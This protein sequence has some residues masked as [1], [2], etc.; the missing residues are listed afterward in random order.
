MET[1]LM[2]ACRHTD[3]RIIFLRCIATA[4][5]QH[6]SIAL[7]ASDKAESNTVI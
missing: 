5:P 4:L 1:L 3:Y 6:L 7:Y 2:K